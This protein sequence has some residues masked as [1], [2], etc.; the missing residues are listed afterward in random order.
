MHDNATRHFPDARR[1]DSPPHRRSAAQRRAAGE[2]HRQAGWR[3]SIRCFPA[4]SHPA[5][6]RL[7]FDAAARTAA[8]LLAPAGPLLRARQVAGPIPQPVG[9]TPGPSGSSTRKA[10]QNP[11]THSQG[12]RDMSDKIRNAVAG[13]SGR[14]IV[15]ERTYRATIEE[16]WELWTTKEGFGSWWAPEGFRAVVH[17]VEAR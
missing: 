8:A 6:S 5:R 2:R 17:A 7:R 15:I 14:K 10:T 16:L 9:N 1:L 12:A 13:A 3:P 4:S 11:K